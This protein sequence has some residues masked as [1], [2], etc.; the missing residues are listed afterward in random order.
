MYSKY[1]IQILLHLLN[2]LKAINFQSCAS[3]LQDS[4]AL[5]KYQHLGSSIFQFCPPILCEEGLWG[6]VIYSKGSIL[7]V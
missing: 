1:S 5:T 2:F 3:E 6:F 4:C 7:R